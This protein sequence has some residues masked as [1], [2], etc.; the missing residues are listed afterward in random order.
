MVEDILQ[1]KIRSLIRCLDRVRQKLPLSA[2]ALAADLDA[3]DIIVVNLQRAVQQAVDI[4]MHVIADRGLPAPADM[5]Q[6]FL[7][8]HEKGWISS[9]TAEVLKRATGFRN[10][11]V[12]EYQKIDWTKVYRIGADHLDDFRRFVEELKNSGVLRL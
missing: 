4:A 11:T 7:R 12:H 2:E 5:G 3:Q 1:T 8:L 9:E 10:V 6:S